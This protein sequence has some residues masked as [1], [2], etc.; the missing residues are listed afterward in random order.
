MRDVLRR[1]I[2]GCTSKEIAYA[3]GLAA[4]TVNTHRKNLLI[5]S[6]CS[7]TAELVRFA[8]SYGLI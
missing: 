4:P 2:V 5:K 8:I 1:I 3:L 6:R 7:N